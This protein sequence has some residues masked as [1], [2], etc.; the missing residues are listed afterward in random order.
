MTR[1]ALAQFR[2]SDEAWWQTAI[3][4][5]EPNLIEIRGYPVQELVGRLSFTDVIALLAIGRLLSDG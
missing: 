3:S 4:R 2:S 1:S 5:N